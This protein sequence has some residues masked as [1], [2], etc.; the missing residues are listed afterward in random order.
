MKRTLSSIL[1]LLLVALLSTGVMAKPDNGHGWGNSNSNPKAENSQKLS[2]PG[3]QKQMESRSQEEKSL[4]SEQKAIKQEQK[5]TRQEEKV[6]KQEQ[7]A[8]K[9]SLQERVK[10]SLREEYRFYNSDNPDQ[11]K[12]VRFTDSQRHWGAQCIEEMAAIGL[13]RGYPDGTF[14]PDQKL[15]QAEALSLAMRVAA[16]DAARDANDEEIS[17]EEQSKLAGIPAWLRGDADKAAKK[18]IIKLNRFHSAVQASRVQVVVM[19]AKALGLEP[20]DTTNIPFKDGLLISRED[21]GYILVLY[22]EGI[23]SGNP[24]G[25]FNPNSA[26]TR[27]EMASI[28]QRLLNKGEIISVSL[29]A[30]ATVQ[31]GKSITLQAVVKY[32]DGSS[33]NNVKWSS[34]DSNLATVENGVV[35]A[36]ADKTGTLNIIATASRGESSKSATCEVTVVEK[37]PVIAASLKETGKVGGH[38]GQ[39]Y[40]EYIF[41]VDTKQISL[42]QDNVKSIS[43]QKDNADALQLTPNTDSTLWF[44]VQKPSGKYSLKVVDKDDKNYEA[45]LE[46]T[47]PVEVAAVATGR[48]GEHNGNS[49][50][51]Y[52]LG[53]LDLS[54]FTCM[55]QIKPD[56]QVSEL[57]ANSDSNLWF[58]TNAQLTGQH[59]FLIKKSNV[60]YSSTISI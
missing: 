24:N 41:E 32:S 28:L 55:F 15:T 54:S 44:N 52:K 3:Q 23:I 18:G 10:T 49:Y 8:V 29:P 33:D 2:A 51:E 13:L 16:D 35:T 9:K 31:Q 59:I 5:T 45:I 19:I 22:Q 38:D 47:A 34:S 58:K 21:V 1:A 30:T 11:R 4:K 40:Q 20:A 6:A 53:D 14:K 36:A 48:S 56:G 37:L 60:W 7:K 26:I 25:N 50:S 39:V 57:T 27:A 42:A 17:D 43:L 46:W 12:A